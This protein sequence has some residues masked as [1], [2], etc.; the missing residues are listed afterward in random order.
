MRNEVSGARNT[1]KFGR[2]IGQSEKRIKQTLE[3]GVEYVNRQVGRAHIT[4]SQKHIVHRVTEDSGYTLQTICGRNLY[5]CE[6]RVVTDPLPEDLCKACER[7]DKRTKKL[8]CQS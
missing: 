6:Y 3:Q 1:N 8:K 4:P 5:K 7:V 2:P